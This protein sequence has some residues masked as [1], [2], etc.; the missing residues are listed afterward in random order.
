VRCMTPQMKK[1]VSV[2]AYLA[3]LPDDARATLE[4]IRRAIEAVAPKATET[5]A[6]GMPAFA[7]AGR[8]LVYHAAVQELQLLPRRLG[9]DGGVLGGA[10]ALR[11]REGHDPVPD[12]EAVAAALVKRIV[13]ARV[14]ETDAHPKR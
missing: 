14:R 7:Y 10:R 2:D 8:P 4:K 6:H 9:G 11:R 13:E 3:D 12:R 1:A 5:I